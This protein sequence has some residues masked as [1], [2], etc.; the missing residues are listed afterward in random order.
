MSETPGVF[1]SQSSVAPAIYRGVARFFHARGLACASEIIL[2]NNR[3][4]DIMA[5][6]AD[7]AITIVEIKSCVAD[8][9][10]DNKWPDYLDYC[11]QFFFAAPSNINLEIFPPDEGLI[12]ADAYGA[13]IVREPQLRK[14]NS[15]RRRA[16]Q[17][18][19]SHCAA[20]RLNAILD[21]GFQL[22]G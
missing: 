2:G 18:N 20:N 9:R 1:V 5:I 22:P 3:R 21:P 7:G 11:D 17:I 12:I 6:S 16:L 19:F 15:A 10:A 8:F 13:N 4:A 14:L